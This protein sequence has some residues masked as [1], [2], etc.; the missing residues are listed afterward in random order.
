[1]KIL[2]TN[3]HQG[4]GGGHDTYIMTLSQEIA[5][6]HEVTVAI[7]KTSLL[8]E[9]LKNCPGIQVFY[10]YF[11][12]KLGRLFS[13]IRE[14]KALRK[15]IREQDFDL[16]HVN[17]SGDHTYVILA[18]LGLKRKPK[19]IF[20]KHNSLKLKWGAKFRAKH[21]C[22][23][24]I[25][26]S[27]FTR[28][29]YSPKLQKHIPIHVVQNGVDISYFSPILGEEAIRNRQK[30]Q[31]P[32]NALVFGSIAGTPQ[33]K[34][35]WLLCEIV[36]KLQARI[37]LPI[38]IL[39]AGNKPPQSFID[40]YVN[41]NGIQDQVIF[42]GFIEDVRSIVSCF[43]VGF[44]LSYDIETISF[45]CREMMAMAKPVIVSDYA[46]LPENVTDE[47]DGWITKAK[48]IDDLADHVEDIVHQR[49]DLVQM[50]KRARQKA[51][52]QF[53]AESFLAATLQV[54]ETIQ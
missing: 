13:V 8:A 37:N 2:L 51:E 23:T 41:A 9:Q 14:I 40:R 26:V 52:N 33:Y 25:A 38:Y 44:V 6:Y 45:A 27:H 11:K 22:D 36:A 16:I 5:K 24:I 1:M 17:G 20:T 28:Q 19:I 30:W 3:F 12:P 42:T 7:P 47:V 48:H 21:F 35:W 31:I 54:Y 15:L 18:I 32:Y 50:G 10:S 43:D 53:S 46:A 39:L 4:C 34:G 29:M 49:Y